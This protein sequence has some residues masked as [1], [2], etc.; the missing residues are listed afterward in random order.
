MKENKHFYTAM[1]LRLSRDDKIAMDDNTVPD[2]SDSG[3]N[4]GISGV[5]KAESNSISS[6]REMIR[7]FIREQPDMELYDSYVDDAD[8]IGLNQKTFDLRGF[9]D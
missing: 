8:I 7:S 1:Y 4:A 3:E 2:N 5:F 9:T 6:Q